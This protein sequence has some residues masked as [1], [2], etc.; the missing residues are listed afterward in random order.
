MKIGDLVKFSEECYPEYKGLI[1]MLT[2]KEHSVDHVGGY[3]WQVMVRG[4]IHPFYVPSEDI[5]AIVGSD[6]DKMTG[7]G[8]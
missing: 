2:G 6:K 7:E 4:R 1:G 8:L 3:R 5:I